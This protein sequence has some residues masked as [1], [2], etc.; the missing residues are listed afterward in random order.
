MGAGKGALIGGLLGGG[1]GAGIGAIFGGVF[2]EST[3]DG[4]NHFIDS[5]R[6]DPVKAAMV[7]KMYGLT[8]DQLRQI[9]TSPGGD[10]QIQALRG[11]FNKFWS[12]K[13]QGPQPGMS[14]KDYSKE[15]GANHID[16]KTAAG[17]QE[18]LARLQQFGIDPMTAYMVEQ[19]QA[20]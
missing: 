12:D 18:Y 1:I 19:H 14:W 3:H 13:N 20:R 16:M 15:T 8:P 9:E 4:N 5:L 2:G 11:Q 7:E 10:K 6:K 17:Q